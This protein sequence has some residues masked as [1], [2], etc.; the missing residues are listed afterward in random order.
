MP[1]AVLTDLFSYK[2]L[3]IFSCILPSSIPEPANL[4]HKAPV[5]IIPLSDELVEDILHRL[6]T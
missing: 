1:L 5:V 2:V 3:D 4:E 6:L